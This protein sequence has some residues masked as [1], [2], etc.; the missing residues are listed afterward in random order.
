M[1]PPRPRRLPCS[2][3]VL[4]PQPSSPHV[5][6]F[7]WPGNQ[8]PTFLTDPDSVLVDNLTRVYFPEDEFHALQAGKVLSEEIMNLKAPSGRSVD[9]IAHSLGNMVVNSAFTFLEPGVVSTYVMHQ[10]AL[11]AEAFSQNY[12]LDTL[13][14]PSAEAQGYPDDQLWET[15]WS[16]MTQG[17]RDAWTLGFPS[18]TP[19]TDV[20]RAFTHRWRLQRPDDWTPATLSGGQSC[21]GAWARR[22]L[23]DAE[24]DQACQH[25]V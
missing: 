17:L 5:V 9:V 19:P 4:L 1:S 13:L 15:M 7:S 3:P 25:V 20:R 2:H 10:A 16:D 6:G 24:K 23:W 8:F 18:G 14:R 11:P 12:G 21:G 22:V